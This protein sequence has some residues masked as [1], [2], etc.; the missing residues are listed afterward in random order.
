[1]EKQ[2]AGQR[3]SR[4]SVVQPIPYQNALHVVNNTKKLEK[5]KEGPNTWHRVAVLIYRL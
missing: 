2:Y 1:M 5:K 3:K 4:T